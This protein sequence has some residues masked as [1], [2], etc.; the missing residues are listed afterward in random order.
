ME[1]SIAIKTIPD[2]LNFL[3]EVTLVRSRCSEKEGGF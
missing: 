2:V 1:I 3:G